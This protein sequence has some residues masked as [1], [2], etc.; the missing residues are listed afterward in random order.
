ML[1]TI[2]WPAARRAIGT[3]AGFAV[4]IS[5]GE[6]GATSFVSRGDAS[7]TA[8]LAVFRLLSQPGGTGEAS[9]TF[10]HALVQEVVVA[11]LT[12]PRCWPPTRRSRA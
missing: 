2:E 6:F 5:L 7:F 3:G 8:P 4:A 12:R 10:R 1:A 11:A 9:A